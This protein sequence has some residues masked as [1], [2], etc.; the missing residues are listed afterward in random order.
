MSRVGSFK[1]DIPN[2]ILKGSVINPNKKEL[3]C[4]VD[5]AERENG[6]KPE[7]S[8]ISS[9]I[10][11]YEAP[12]ILCEFLMKHIKFPQA[13]SIASVSTNNIT[14]EIQLKEEENN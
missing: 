10:I 14:K 1:T 4:C 6:I 12:I 3:N 7:P 9:D 11:K 13:K 5:W 2:C 8:W